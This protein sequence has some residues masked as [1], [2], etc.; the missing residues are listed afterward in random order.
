M[1]HI[2]IGGNGFTGRL[3]VEEL[4][5]RGLQVLVCDN[6]ATT[7][8][9]GN[10]ATEFVH[11]DIERPETLAALNIQQDDVVHLLAAR[12]Y[13]S[14]VPKKN[15][16]EFFSAVNVQGTEN[17]LNHMRDCGASKAIFFSTD[18]VYGYPQTLPIETSHQREPLGP[19][20]LSK[21][22]AE[23]VCR[24]FREQGFQITIFRPRMIVGPGR[25]GVLEK[26]FKLIEKNLP[27]PLIGNG[28][29]HY[30]M[31]SV[32]DCV[33]AITCALEKGIP[34]DEFNLGSEN[35]PTVHELLS[36]LIESCGSRSF[37]LKTPAPLV[38]AVLDVFDKVGL[39]VLFKEQY[40]ISDHNYLVD[41][42]KTKNELGW[43]PQHNDRDMFQ[44]TFQEYKSLTA[45]TA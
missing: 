23:A 10:A 25:L 18:M 27:V 31:V 40:A 19:Y 32:F 9:K 36:S 35:P 4:Q 39:T 30:Q 37:L 34:N 8:P 28:S 21:F 11:A 43:V 14:F 29:N 24:S 15:R 3:L 20:G 13:H 2:V 16:N 33:S 17:V 42:D 22:R 6:D 41:I 12:Q 5:R 26:L 44:Q 45:A 1:K 38:K 7:A